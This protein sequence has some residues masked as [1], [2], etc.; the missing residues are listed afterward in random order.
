[1]SPEQSFLLA[2]YSP[3]SHGQCT[4][5]EVFLKSSP[6]IDYDVWECSKQISVLDSTTQLPYDFQFQRVY[7]Q[8]NDY[9]ETEI[10]MTFSSPNTNETLY[11]IP[12]IPLTQLAASPSSMADNRW[13]EEFIERMKAYESQIQS[14][15]ALVTQ[16]LTVQQ[17]SLSPPKRDV[18]V[19]TSPP[20]VQSI[21]AD[22]NSVDILK[23]IFSFLDNRQQVTSTTT[24]GISFISNNGIQMQL[25]NQQSSTTTVYP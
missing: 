13:K 5:Y 18:G 19:Q 1:M 3:T 8:S 10:S 9:S 11:G 25:I 16:L 2:C 15:T 17:N 14:L 6:T 4:F 12:R 20:T 22:P 23:P 7:N 21:P 24:T